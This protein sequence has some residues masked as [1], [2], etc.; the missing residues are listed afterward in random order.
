MSVSTITLLSAVHTLLL[1]DQH[2]TV[3]IRGE[4]EEVRHDIKD[5]D[6]EQDSR[7]VERDLF[8]HL[9]HA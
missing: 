3:E 7:I 8:G 4:D 2:A 9:H 6:A 5:A 1:L